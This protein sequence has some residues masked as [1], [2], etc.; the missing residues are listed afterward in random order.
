MPGAFIEE[1]L[2]SP[3]QH[4]NGHITYTYEQA[5]AVDRIEWN[6]GEI[7]VFFTASL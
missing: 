2:G 4:K 5:A 7:N 6:D 3:R 1:M